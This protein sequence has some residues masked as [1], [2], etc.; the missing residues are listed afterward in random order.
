MAAKQALSAKEQTGNHLQAEALNKSNSELEEPD[1][2]VLQFFHPYSSFLAPFLLF[3]H[4][5]LLM[6][7]SYILTHAFIY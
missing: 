3:S 4:A 1:P 7:H 2:L 5:L 6:T